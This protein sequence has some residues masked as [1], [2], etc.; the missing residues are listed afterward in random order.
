MLVAGET[1]V[2]LLIAPNQRQAK[3]SL[4]YAEATLKASP[5]LRQLIANR[6]AETLELTNGIHIEVR[7]RASVAC[8]VRLI[9]RDRRRGSVLVD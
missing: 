4:D 2:V 8:A 1:G 9:L 3:I 6:N 7:P 5:I